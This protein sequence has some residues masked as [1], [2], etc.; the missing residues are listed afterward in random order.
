[1]LVSPKIEPVSQPRLLAVGDSAWT[2]EFGDRIDPLIN[3]RVMGL[4]GSLVTARETGDEPLLSA[5]V[6][7]VPTFRSVT[8]HFDP[9]VADPD[10]L[11]Q[12][13]LSLAQTSGL[14]ARH[15]RH[16]RLPVCFEGDLAPDLDRVAGACGLGRDEVVALMSSTAFRVYM[17]GFMPG[18]PYM[19][20]L[21]AVLNVPRLASPRKRVPARALAIAGE[22]CAVYPWESPGGWNLIGRLPLPLFAARAEPP[23]L[24]A[25]GDVV[26]WQVIDHATYQELEQALGKGDFDASRFLVS[27]ETS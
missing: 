13:L 4:T 11:G 16:W 23:A 2:I 18:F 22:M 25:A 14:A 9:L 7:V 10:Q 12:R 24:L 5:V 19:G 21:P 8:V 17:I 20:G 26:E 6:D 3:A 1:M 15:G 27:G